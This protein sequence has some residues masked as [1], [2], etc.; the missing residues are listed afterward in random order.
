MNK[1]D[2]Y[3]AYKA[4]EQSHM[5]I[6]MELN[7]LK[8]NMLQFSHD[9]DSDEKNKYYKKIG[10]EN[11]KLKEKYEKFRVRNCDRME[12]LVKALSP[13]KKNHQDHKRILEAIVELKEEHQKLLDDIELHPDYE[14]TIKSTIEEFIKSMK[15]KI[16]EESDDEEDAAQAAAL[17]AFDNDSD[18]EEV[19]FCGVNGHRCEECTDCARSKVCDTCKCVGGCYEDC[20]SNR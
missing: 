18:D 8:E 12:E 9:F 16:D 20:L 1:A 17:A 15:E 7:E 13:W 10:E 4:L 19:S 14:E 2:L 3:K 5:K 6:E 11:E